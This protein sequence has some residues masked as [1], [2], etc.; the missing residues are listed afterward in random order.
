MGI[1]NEYSLHKLPD[2]PCC[3]NCGGRPYTTGLATSVPPRVHEDAKGNPVKS[4]VRCDCVWVEVE[5]HDEIGRLWRIYRRWRHSLKGD[6]LEY[7]DVF[8]VRL[9]ET[10]NSDAES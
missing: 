7:P 1:P 5:K 4:C 3:P 10:D 9:V 8:A 2:F 6:W